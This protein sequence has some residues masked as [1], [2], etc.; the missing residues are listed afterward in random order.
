[1]DTACSGCWANGVSCVLPCFNILHDACDAGLKPRGSVLGGAAGQQQPAVWGVHLNSA[2]VLPRVHT[3]VRLVRP[4]AKSDGI[5]AVP[6]AGE[7]WRR[8]AASR[9]GVD[10]RNCTHTGCCSASSESERNESGVKATPPLRRGRLAR[11]SARRK[12][13]LLATPLP[14]STTTIIATVPA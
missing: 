2:A 11:V 13:G 12:H 5:A 6:G 4:D 3:E 14:P 9:G 7:A 8:C 10:E 1:M